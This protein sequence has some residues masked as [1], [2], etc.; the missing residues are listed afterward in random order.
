MG[1]GAGR[2]NR[3]LRPARLAGA[4]AGAEDGACV[5]LVQGVVARAERLPEEVEVVEE[6]VPED[7]A[8]AVGAA[9]NPSSKLSTSG[10]EMWRA[11]AKAAPGGRI[12]RR[13]FV[14]RHV[15]LQ[16]AACATP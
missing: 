12:R 5:V 13:C 16:R 15:Q 4:A 7:A 3:T 1:A 6:A 2:S 11:V 9:H 8:N 14:V 10:A